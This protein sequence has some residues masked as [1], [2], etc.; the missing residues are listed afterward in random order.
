MNNPEQVIRMF[1]TA[2]QNKDYKTMQDCYA[3]KAVFNDP[4]FP[5]LNARQVRAMWEM[6]CVRSRDL[7]IELGNI[8]ANDTEG[9]AEWTASYTFSSTGK[10]VINRIKSKFIF[11]NGKILRHSDSF[12]FYRWASQA[13]GLS[14]VLLGWLPFVRNKAQKAAMM[15]LNNY[16]NSSKPG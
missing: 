10:K 13:L 16:M 6:F 9:V 14:G 12:N 8:K 15:A 4:V 11:E 7:T 5:D 1:Y 2:F 3:N